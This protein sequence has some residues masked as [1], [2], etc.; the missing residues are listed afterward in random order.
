MHMRDQLHNNFR[1]F[2]TLSL[3]IHVFA[4]CGLLIFNTSQK[5]AIDFLKVHANAHALKVKVLPFGH[6]KPRSKSQS[7]IQQSSSS[8]IGTKLLSSQSSKTTM[9]KKTTTTKTV[10]EKKRSKKNKKQNVK[11]NVALKEEKTVPKQEIKQEQPPVEKK[12]E[13]AQ[14]APQ[15]IIPHN[16]GATFTSESSDEFVYVTQDELEALKIG[17]ALQEAVSSAWSPPAGMDSEVECAVRIIINHE[18]KL[19]ETVYEKVSGIRIYDV[20]VERAVPHIAFPQQLW[21]KSFV[22]CFKP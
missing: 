18:G 1:F 14:A 2:A 21:G 5:T 4:G 10:Q 15:E 12:E 3:I 16:E 13:S 9:S 22:L 11:K 6:K 19:V 8:S 17:V 20:T 7:G